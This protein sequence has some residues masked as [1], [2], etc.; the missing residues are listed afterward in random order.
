MEVS[1]DV[2]IIGA[3]GAG[4]R[5]AYEI[6]KNKDIDVAVVSKIFPTRSHTGAAQGG[7]NAAL[8]N[9]RDKGE[10][11]IDSHTFDTVKGSDYLGD[12]DAIEVMC[13]NAPKDI[14]ELEHMGC[15]F[16]RDDDGN[17]AQRPFG[18]AGFPRTCYSADIT[19]H[20]ILHTLYEQLLK[21][22]VKFYNEFFVLSLIIEEDLIKGVI[23]IDIATGELAVMKA[24]TVILA[25]GGAGRV[26][27][28]STNA[29]VST[30][31]GI[32]IAYRAG[33]PLKDMEF[34]QFHP[35]TL[36]SNGVLISEAA[37]G[38]GGYLLNKNEERFMEKYAPSAKELASRDV[39]ARAEQTEIN[40]GRGVDGCVLLDLRHLGKEKI[41]SRLPQI[42]ELALDFAGVDCIDEPIPVKPGAHYYMG[43][44]DVNVDGQ[45]SINGLFACGECACLSVHGANRLGGNSLLETIVFGKLAG[46]KAVDYFS[47]TGK[48]D[49]VDPRHLEEVDVFLKKL[50]E[51]DGIENVYSIRDD[52]QKNMNENVGIFRSEEKIQKGLDEIEKL[53][54]RYLN[55]GISDKGKVYNFELTEYFEIGYLLDLAEATAKSALL[56]EES[57]GSH[58]RED[59]PERND[60]KFLNHSMT[61]FNRSGL[62]NVRYKRVEITK[63]KP[64]ERKY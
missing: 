18:G 22:G 41:L 13:K 4:M 45:T 59:F 50:H 54:E 62:P 10:D 33:A 26:Y 37:R 51:K 64:M 12:Q 14:I 27:S 43:G 20:V 6:A 58:Q 32:A 48:V 17:I 36:A 21:K 63:Y 24:S 8:N 60:S 57:R 15:L 25:T 2:L 61:Y 38:E 34:V 39:V 49:D 5:A 42:R 35:T 1:H 40:E 7:I 16:S 47:E 55:V 23:A 9:N 19:G 53:K 30:G 28:G 46:K 11:S 29:L 52:L 44:I 3:G 56:R 31:D